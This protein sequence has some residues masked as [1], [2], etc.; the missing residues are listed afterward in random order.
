MAFSD[1]DLPVGGMYLKIKSGE[2]YTIRMMQ[3]TPSVKTLHG[4][5]KEAVKCDGTGCVMCG[6]ANN[7]N[8]KA[9][10][11]FSINVYSHDQQKVLVWEFGSGICGQIREIEESLKKQ[12]LTLTETD[13]GITA[14]GEN[15]EKR[16][17]VQPMIKSRPVPEGLTLYE[18]ELPT[19]DIPF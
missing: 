13:L 7:K 3:D 14:K 11:R 12:G 4:F 18:L 1:L 19:L 5:G 17:M 16:Y 2:A 15:M 9:K 6:D 8:R 10:Q